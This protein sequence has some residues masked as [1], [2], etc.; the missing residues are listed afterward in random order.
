[1]RVYNQLPAA[2]ATQGTAQQL[3]HPAYAHSSNLPFRQNSEILY[4]LVSKKSSYK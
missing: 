2:Q 3:H 4:A 1:M